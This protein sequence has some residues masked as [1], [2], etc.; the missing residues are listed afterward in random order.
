MRLLNGGKSCTPPTRVTKE[1]ISQTLLEKR[2][3]STRM[4]T[5]GKIKGMREWYNNLFS[6]DLTEEG[7]INYLAREFYKQTEGY[8]PREW[9]TGAKIAALSL[10]GALGAGAG[11]ATTR[12]Y[13]RVEHLPDEVDVLNIDSRPQAEVIYEGK[14]LGKTPV[15]LTVSFKLKKRTEIEG[16]ERRG[17]TTD[18]KVRYTNISSEPDYHVIKL[19]APE[20]FEDTVYYGSNGISNNRNIFRILKKEYSPQPYMH[21]EQQIIIKQEGK[22][23]EN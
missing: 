12:Y 22:G 13:D 5:E 4:A 11:C 14:S 7:K 15:Q 9:S 8:T 19:Y 18:E 1:Y 3:R 2:K 17:R 21:Q 20:H 23:R 6:S 10:I 16:T